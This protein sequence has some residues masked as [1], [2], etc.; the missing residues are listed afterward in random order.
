MTNSLPKIS[1]I[2][3]NYNDAKGLEETILSVINQSYQNIEY[4]II[5]GGSSDNSLDIIKKYEDKIDS[6]ISE[7]DKGVFDAMNKGIKQCTGDW[8]NFMNSADSFYD[9]NVIS[10]MKFD[11]S[12][13]IYGDTINL[14][15]N[16]KQPIFEMDS[17]KYGRIM[18]C[19]QAMFFNLRNY[20]KEI[21]Y[22]KG[23]QLLADYELVNRLWK[24]KLK[25]TYQPVIV[26]NYLLGGI[27]SQISW[28]SRKAKFYTVAKSYGIIGLIRVVLER[29]NLIGYKPI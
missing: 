13:L 2:T 16:K 18:A 12:A 24:K 9:N 27:S 4:I 8:V 19:H 26:A 15:D 10:K 20:K 23:L 14:P 17:L 6:W 28:E 21:Y 1:I 5:D 22:E 11:D 25:I 29:I 7:S 3:I